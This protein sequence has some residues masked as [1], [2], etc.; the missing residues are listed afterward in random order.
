VQRPHAPSFAIGG[1]LVGEEHGAELACHGVECAFTEREL[2]GIGL[3]P[4]DVIRVSVR[5]GKVEQRL[6]NRPL[7]KCAVA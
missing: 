6:V 1:Y 4:G 7:T 5:R 3:P 2:Q